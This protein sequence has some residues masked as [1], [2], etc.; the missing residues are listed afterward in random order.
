MGFLLCW[1]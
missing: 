1:E